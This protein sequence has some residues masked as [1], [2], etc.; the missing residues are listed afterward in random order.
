MRWKSAL[1]FALSILVALVAAGYRYAD[2]SHAMGLLTMKG[3]KARHGFQIRS[4]ENLY[5]LIATASVLPPVRGDVR[6]SLE[7]EPAMNYAIYNTEPI[8]DLGLHRKPRLENGILYGVQPRDRL[9]FWVMMQPQVQTEGQHAAGWLHT[10]TALTGDSSSAD[11]PLAL[12]FTDLRTGRELLRIPVVFT[13]KEE[14]HHG[15]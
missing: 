15:G 4:G 1:V 13:D 7:G 8:I 10:P 14:M 6:V 3:G 11:H 12:R 9:A 5:A 2:S